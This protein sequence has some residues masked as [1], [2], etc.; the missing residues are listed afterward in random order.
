MMQV[1]STC[2][3]AAVPGE[4]ERVRRTAPGRLALLTGALLLGLALLGMTAGTALAVTAGKELTLT[5]RYGGEGVKECHGC[6]G[7]SL[8][9]HAN[10]SNPDVETEY[11]MPV[12]AETDRLKWHIWESVP[13]KVSTDGTWTLGRPRWSAAHSNGS[14]EFDPSWN[15]LDFR[16]AV[17][18]EPEG[19]PMCQEPTYTEKHSDD[20]AKLYL[21]WLKSARGGLPHIATRGRIHHAIKVELVSP[22]NLSAVKDTGYFSYEANSPSIENSPLD[23][24]FPA[25]NVTEDAYPCVWDWKALN[26]RWAEI[27]RPSVVWGEERD[28]FAKSVIRH[29]EMSVDETFPAGQ[30]ASGDWAL[31]GEPKYESMDVITKIEVGV[32]DGR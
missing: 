27:D 14:M 17:F 15:C 22:L 1:R 7:S 31:V 29:P 9:Q 19:R 6:F 3:G 30:C 25:W 20:T 13:I 23:W 2:V 26:K 10:P 5:I 11:E 16:E 32:H 21:P 4:P 28:G 12:G 18:G 8:G 24:N